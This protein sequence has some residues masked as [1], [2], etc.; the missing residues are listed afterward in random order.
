MK[1]FEV[2]EFDIKSVSQAFL[3]NLTLIFI[4]NKWEDYNLF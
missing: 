1:Y 2:V 4:C 3:S